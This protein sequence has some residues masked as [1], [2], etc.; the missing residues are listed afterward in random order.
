MLDPQLTAQ[1]R[2]HLASVTMPVELVASIDGSPKST[3]MVGLLD[4]I[5]ALSPHVTVR[6]DGDATRRPSFAIQR[7]G[8]DVRVEFAGIPLGHEFTSLVLALLH[9]GGRAPRVTDEV[10]EQIRALPGGTF[11]TFFSLSCQ[12]CPDVV[13]ALNVMSVLNPRIRHIS[14]DGAVFRDEVEQRG[15]LS[16]PTVF[17]DGESFTSGRSSIEQLVALLDAGAATRAAAEIDAKDTF[18][19]LVVGGGPAGASAA[20]YAARKGIRTGVVAERFGGQVLDT[21]AIENFV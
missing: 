6:R 17:R 14:I 16:V 2:T 19:V 20:V 21:M 18:D 3:E 12:N 8:T 9:V 11:E 10:A 1:L 13:Q 5:A 7:T 4:E 15:V